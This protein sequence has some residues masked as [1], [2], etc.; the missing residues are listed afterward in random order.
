MESVFSTQSGSP[1]HGSFEGYAQV[2]GAVAVKIEA[3]HEEDGK[4]A[5]D[6]GVNVVVNVGSRRKR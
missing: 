3:R 4:D 6:L 1:H 5:S 2:L